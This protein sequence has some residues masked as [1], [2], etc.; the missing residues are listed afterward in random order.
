MS[1]CAA[2]FAPEALPPELGAIG[3]IVAS[4]LIGA[5]LIKRYL[6]R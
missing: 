1:V 4:M 3:V 6:A 2:G 5:P